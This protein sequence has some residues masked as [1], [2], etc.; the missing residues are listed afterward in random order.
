MTIRTP[1]IDPAEFAAAAEAIGQADEIALGCHVGPD[2]DALGSMIGFGMAAVNAGKKVIAGFGSPFSVPSNL[3]FLP[4]GLLVAPDDFPASPELMVVFDAG[5]QERLAE[6]G[7]AAGDA[8]RL[9]VVDH[10]VTNVGFGD[11]A[12]VDP[13]A[14][15]SAVIVVRLLDTLGW[16]I[17]ADIATCLHTALVTDTGRFQYAN[18]SPDTLLL[19]ARLVEAGARPEQIS[20][21]VYEEAPFGYIKAA[22]AA[23]SRATLDADLSMVSTVVTQEDLDEAGIDWG[24]ID[25]LINTLRLAEEADVAVLAKVSDSQVK[26]SLR[27]RGG[28]DVGSLAAELGGG[29]HRLASGFTFAGQA[30]SA[31]DEIRKRI[32]AHR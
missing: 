6:L 19:A 18:T 26:L 22:G 14:A 28:T 2:G 32:E 1:M 12:L 13:A 24:D 3:A 11:I 30:E 7:S 16:P 8:G 29:G 9:I 31:L 27:S 10:H 4:L 20:Q 25:N 21:K 23:L 5:S 17:T 15:A